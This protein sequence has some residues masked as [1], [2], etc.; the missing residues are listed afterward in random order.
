VRCSKTLNC[1]LAILILSFTQLLPRHKRRCVAALLSVP[2]QLS[3]S[4]SPYFERSGLWHELQLKHLRDCRPIA[5]L[6]FPAYP[7]LPL[8]L[9]IIKATPTPFSCARVVL[10]PVEL[11]R[12]PDQNIQRCV[13][14]T[15]RTC[16][17]NYCLLKTLLIRVWEAILN[18]MLRILFRLRLDLPSISD[19]TCFICKHHLFA[20][21]R[22]LTWTLLSGR[23]CRF[24]AHAGI[25]SAGRP[26]AL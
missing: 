17:H 9:S 18:V 25:Q 22:A 3:P 2:R 21:R 4:P 26:L 15:G 11:L 5:H 12:E 24:I 6:F 19:L 7:W 16:S 23:H 13:G 8:F 20:D 10:D 1:Y 14:Q